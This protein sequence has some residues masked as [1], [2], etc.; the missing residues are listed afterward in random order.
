MRRST[1]I[2]G[3]DCAVQPERIGLALGAWHDG[4]CGLI[5]SAQAKTGAG[6]VRIVADW[7]QTAPGPVLLAMDAPLGWPV[8]LGR[9]LA[10]HQAGAPLEG[11]ANELFRRHT[12][13]EIRGRLGKQPLDVGA[14]RIARTALAALRLLRDLRDATGLEIPLAWGPDELAGAGAIEVYPAGTLLAHDI[15]PQ[16]YKGKDGTSARQRMIAILARLVDL[17]EK[18]A[19]ALAAGDDA[20]DAAICVLAGADFL[21]GRAIGPTDLGLA[22]K[23]GWIWCQRQRREASFCSAPQE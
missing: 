6:I 15:S 22:R 23:E 3:I 21:A 2:I 4:Q 13:R 17:P 19:P 9:G 16:G 5:E 8:A 14:D 1:T 10:E 18:L 12:D 20:L 11:D 7:M